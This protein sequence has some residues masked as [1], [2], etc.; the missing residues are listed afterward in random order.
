MTI[1]TERATAAL[2]PPSTSVAVAKIAS[3]ARSVAASRSRRRSEVLRGNSRA[4][5]HG[6]YAR[7]ANQVDVACEIALTMAAHPDLD[8]IGDLRLVE[9]YCLASTSYRRALEAIERDGLT[10]VL[11]SCAARF[12]QLEERQEER[13]RVREKE[14]RA[15]LRRGQIVDLSAYR[16][17]PRELTE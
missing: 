11:T 6:V 9:S 17:V 10:A 7:V 14:R 16:P 5:S 8:P 4:F 1:P 12:A 2:M 13:I 15:E 3:P